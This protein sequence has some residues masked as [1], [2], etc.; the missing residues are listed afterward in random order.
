M[1]SGEGEP[2]EDD[3][4]PKDCIMQRLVIRPGEIP[5]LH[6]I[7][8]ATEGKASKAVDIGMVGMAVPRIAVRH[9]AH[10]VSGA[11]A[12]TEAEI[13]ETPPSD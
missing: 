3:A 5:G 8:R 4:N 7:V 12:P 13:R 9:V 6:Q 11:G 2:P 10:L 1:G